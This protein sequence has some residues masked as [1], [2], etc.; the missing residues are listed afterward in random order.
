MYLCL[1]ACVLLLNT[2]RKGC[3]RQAKAAMK[4]YS[5]NAL[6]KK[7]QKKKSVSKHFGTVSTAHWLV[8]VIYF[9]AGGPAKWQGYITQPTVNNTDSGLRHLKSVQWFN[10]HLRQA[11]HNTLHTL[12][13]ICRC[14]QA[15]LFRQGFFFSR[16]VL[17]WPV[18]GAIAPC[19]CTSC[20]WILLLYH[21]ILI[22]AFLFVCTSDK[23]VIVHGA[24][25][26][27]WYSND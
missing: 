8:C 5:N 22:H 23:W 1:H 2:G 11:P 18:N 3:K 7:Q 4:L 9:W 16:D 13:A 24:R 6:F 20:N 12:S 26:Q 17:I 15:S 27:F 21:S 19:N 25:S 14:C 10:R